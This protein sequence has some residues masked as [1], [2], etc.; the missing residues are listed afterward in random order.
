MKKIMVLAALFMG[1]II[2]VNAQENPLKAY[3]G[4]YTF[5][6]GS[7]VAEMTI[8]IE[9]SSLVINSAMGSTAIEK[10][11]TDTFYLAQYDANVIFKRGA[12]KIVTE[13]A[14]LVQGMEL[15][16]KREAEVVTTPSSN[17]KT[18]MEESFIQIWMD[19]QT[20]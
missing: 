5:A 2:S 12:D 13:V 4:K 15:V 8:T 10:K 20:R 19:K 18:T 14:I 17:P 3:L 7:P 1:A 11:A 6:P 9:D 16:G